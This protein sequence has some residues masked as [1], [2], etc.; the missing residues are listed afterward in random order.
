MSS[1]SRCGFYLA[2]PSSIGSVFEF[3]MPTC[4]ISEQQCCMTKEPDSIGSIH[5]VFPSASL[6]SVIFQ[7]MLSGFGFIRD[8]IQCGFGTAVCFFFLVTV[9]LRHVAIV[10]HFVQK[11]NVVLRNSGSRSRRASAFSL[12]QD[13]CERS[14]K[15]HSLSRLQD[16]PKRCVLLGSSCSRHT[17]HGFVEPTQRLRSPLAYVDGEWDQVRRRTRRG[18]YFAFLDGTL[19]FADQWRQDGGSVEKVEENRSEFRCD[20][21][22]FCVGSHNQRRDKPVPAKGGGRCRAK[23]GQWRHFSLDHEG[24]MDDMQLVLVQSMVCGPW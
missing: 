24:A 8:C 3:T 23:R 22:T 2:R 1:L 13:S 16:T 20:I 15:T 12:L 21:Y 19:P 10:M 7:R 17:W 9:G 6:S 11:N 14:W 18:G 4:R 5:D